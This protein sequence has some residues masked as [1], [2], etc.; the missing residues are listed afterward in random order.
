MDAQDSSRTLGHYPNESYHQA[1]M[2]LV[3]P[4]LYTS[5]GNTTTLNSITWTILNVD[6]VYCE[7][8]R[9][10]WK[11]T[12]VKKSYF[13]R[14][15]NLSFIHFGILFGSLLLYNLN[16]ANRFVVNFKREELEH[17]SIN[18]LLSLSLKC[19]KL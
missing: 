1:E 16:S 8:N 13:Y 18:G 4:T 11:K 7:K 6:T 10:I 14:N 19:A 12:M 5:K 9:F 15:F 17:S 2:T 3:S